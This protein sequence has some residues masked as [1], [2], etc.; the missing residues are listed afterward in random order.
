[1]TTGRESV[2]VKRKEQNG[3]QQQQA[4]GAGCIIERCVRCVPAPTHRLTTRYGRYRCLNS[5]SSSLPVDSSSGSRVRKSPTTYSRSIGRSTFVP[6]RQY[7][8][9]ENIP[10][11]MIRAVLGLLLVTRNKVPSPIRH[12]VDRT[13]SLPACMHRVRVML[14]SSSYTCIYR[15]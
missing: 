5:S 8:V 4:H 10:L 13:S 15:E 2:L 11:R 7:D 6:V 1:M 14:G 9:L 3:I 12:T